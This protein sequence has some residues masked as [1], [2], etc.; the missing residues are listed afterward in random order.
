M[1]VM[2]DQPIDEAGNESVAEPSS[3]P[4]DEPSSG[5][6]SGP[7]VGVRVLE[8]A[9][10][11]PGPFAAMVLAD[12]GAEVLRIDRPGGASTMQG[13]PAYDVMLRGR[14]NAC[15]D[16]KQSAAIDAV[17]RL[18]AR[19]DVLI[20]V[21]RP[22]VMERLGLGPD[23]CLAANPRLIYTRMTGWG[24]DGPLARVAGHDITY[25]APTGALHATGRAGGP[26]QLA[27]NMLG[28][29]GA[30][31]TFCL[32]GILAALHERVTSGRGQVV[33]ASIVDG[34]VL[35]TAQ[36]QG[37]VGAGLWE[38]TRGVNLLD[39][40]A[41]YYDVYETSDGE[42]MAVGA[43]EPKFY[44]ALL[45][46]L[47][48]DPEQVPDRR[49]AAQWPRLRTALAAAFAARSQAEWVAVFEGTDA[50]VAA[51]LSLDRATQ[52]PHLEARAAYVQVDGVTQPAPAPRF[53]RT[54]G[55][56]STGPARTGQHTRDALSEWGV[57]DV[58]GLIGSGA[59]RQ[60]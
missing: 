8:M 38:P 18:V 36:L 42:H 39:T 21:F 44:A 13:D 40:G 47:Q 41:P 53:S 55:A 22:G 32:I 24:Q 56:V 11:G 12:L 20:D 60:G 33:D 25:L 1:P 26:P 43:L 14:R 30:G 15:L 19:T 45:A 7:L 17:R 5:Q 29:Y 57:H 48:L 34:T 10:Q 58:Q 50:C 16:L 4:M 3:E 49:D 52:N 6:R 35:L 27:A 31:G 9:G 46:G 23:E 2:S 51:V 54:P 28:D 59:A 37:L